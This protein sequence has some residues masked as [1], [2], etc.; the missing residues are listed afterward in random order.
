M[1]RGGG[2]RKRG[3]C[4]RCGSLRRRCL[5]R[6]L[7][8]RRIRADVHAY[9]QCL[10]PNPA[11]RAAAGHH[12]PR[13]TLEGVLAALLARRNPAVAALAPALVNPEQ[14][15]VERARVPEADGGL[16]RTALGAQFLRTEPAPGCRR[17]GS[18]I[19]R[20]PCTGTGIDVRRRPAAA[21]EDAD[22]VTVHPPRVR[23]G[24]DQQ[25]VP[26]GRGRSG[27]QHEDGTDARG[28]GCGH[29]TTIR[30]H[31]ATHAASL[32]RYASWREAPSIPPCGP[33]LRDHRGLPGGTPPHR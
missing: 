11:E 9:R 28:Q 23:R 31:E 12:L 30:T 6:L 2:G 7:R 33:R 13:V 14:F 8:Y 27:R 22:G 18:G 15:R 21:R 16:Q 5:R 1:E 29:R 10:A 32:R 25:R 4:R 26:V 3:R 17:R 19:E 20:D 24:V